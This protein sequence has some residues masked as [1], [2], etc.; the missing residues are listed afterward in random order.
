MNF[1][2][3][4]IV[5]SNA[6]SRNVRAVPDDSDG[7]QLPPALRQF[8]DGLAE[9]IAEDLYRKGWRAAESEGD[10]PDMVEPSAC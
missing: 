1:E 2:K 7:A 4:P 10:A 5:A 9:M 8:L 3:R 6:P